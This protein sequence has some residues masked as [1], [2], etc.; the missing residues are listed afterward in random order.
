M[1]SFLVFLIQIVDPITIV[2]IVPESVSNVPT[3]GVDLEVSYFRQNWTLH[4]LVLFQTD[5]F[6][7]A[8]MSSLF[9][10]AG[11]RA[12][13]TCYY[14]KCAECLNDSDCSIGDSCLEYYCIG[15]TRR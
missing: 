6:C 5:N 7:P 13:K 12:G 4:S 14:Y 3:L 10:R 2:V 1:D 8:F 15:G 11:L 9:G